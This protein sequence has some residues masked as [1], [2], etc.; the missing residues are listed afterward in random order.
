MLDGDDHQLIDRWMKEGVYKDT[1]ERFTV[2]G[3]KLYADGA[4][5]ARGAWLLKP[6][7]DKHDTHGHAVMDM[8]DVQKMAQRCLQSGFQLCTHAIGDRANREVLN[9]YESALQVEP[10]KDHRFRIEHAQHL[11][12]KDIPTFC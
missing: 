8:E 11:T 10:K 3:V 7:K 12:E 2:G 4:L 5:G 1:S 9:R 6:Y